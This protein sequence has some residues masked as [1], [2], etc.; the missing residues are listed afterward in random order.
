[1]KKENTVLYI[2]KL[3]LILFLITAVVAAALAGVNALTQDRI[4]GLNAQKTAQAISLVLDSQAE[5]ELLEDPE[6][7]REITGIYRLGED[8][9]AISLTLSGSQANIEIMVGTDP[10]GVI[11]GVSM[12][13][14]KETSGMGATYA[15][16]TAA[17]VSFRES[18]VG[19][20]GSFPVSEVDYK[21]GATVTAQAI[22][23]G[24]AIASSYVAGLQ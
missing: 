24:A 3:G 18:F 6:A 8:G 4:A 23:D 17:G 2:L 15:D 10:Q 22:C 14:H 16:N 19:K 11:T 21:S 5:P 20:S 12:V 7:P 1:M 13:S 9:Y